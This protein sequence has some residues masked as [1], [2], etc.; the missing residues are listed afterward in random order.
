VSF[1]QCEGEGVVF[2]ASELRLPLA[3][4][5]HTTSVA[6][7]GIE[8]PVEAGDAF[9]V[10][11][12]AKCG[13]GCAVAGHEIEVLDQAGRPLAAGRLGERAWPGTAALF[14]CAVPLEAPTEAGAFRWSVRLGAQLD[15]PHQG[16][17]QAFS[18]AVLPRPEHRLTVEVLEAAAGAP[19]AGAMVRIGPWRGVT[20]TAGLASIGLPRGEHVVAAWKTQYRAASRKLTLDG[21]T[22]VRLT[23][24]AIPEENPEDIWI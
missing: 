5:A 7:W 13:D 3:T 17:A 18:F 22:R 20:D 8:G 11:V 23:I 14:W 9:T 24:E 21:D 19:V 4:R 6:V 10:H 1:P 2:E 16:S 12:G 15:L